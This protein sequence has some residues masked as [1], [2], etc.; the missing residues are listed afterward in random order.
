MAWWRRRLS[1]GGGWVINCGG[2][3]VTG[4]GGSRIASLT[5]EGVEFAPSS[6]EGV[7]ICGPEAERKMATAD[8]L[9]MPPRGA[10]SFR[11]GLVE[12][13]TTLIETG[14]VLSWWNRNGDFRLRSQQ[15]DSLPRWTHLIET[16][17]HGLI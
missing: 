8:A 10:R 1:C 11:V 14:Q 12:M 16:Q 4:V 15:R 3:L 17:T 7:L 6:V 9:S 5:A 2:G 13:V